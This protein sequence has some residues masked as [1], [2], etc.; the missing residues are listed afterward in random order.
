[1]YVCISIETFYFLFP[2]FIYGTCV[3][4]YIYFFE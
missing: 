2:Y 4:I 1:M 3:E